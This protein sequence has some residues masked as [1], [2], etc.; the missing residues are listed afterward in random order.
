MKKV[1]KS[2]K[3]FIGVTLVAIALLFVQAF[4]DL[5]LPNYMSSIVNVGIQ[6]SGIEHASPESF[7]E[8]GY[9]FIASLLP[10]AQKN[11]FQDAYHLDSGVYKIDTSL[12]RKEVDL[13][14]SD[15]ITTLMLLDIEGQGGQGSIEVDVNIKDLYAATPLFE[16]MDKTEAYEKAQMKEETV[17]LQTGVMVA[18]LLYEDQGIST[19]SMQTNYIIKTGA[20]MLAITLLGALA[21]ISVSYVSA[22]IGAGFSRRLRN[23]I[24]SKVES[25]SSVEFNEFSSSSLVIRTTNDVTQVQQ[26]VVMGIRMFFYAPIMALGGIYYINQTETSLT[27]I[28]VVACSIIAVLFLFVALVA[29]PKFKIVQKYV[30]RLTL[31]F[32]EN[33]NGVMVIR[34]FG[35]KKFENERFDK[36]NTDSANLSRFINRIMSSMMPL[37][38][39][40]MNLT[41]I[42]ILW[43]GAEQVSA[44]TM[45]VGDMM[46]F[47]QYTMQIIM[48]FLMIA[49]MFIFVPRAIVSL[50]RITEILDRDNV[51]VDPEN[52]Q[53]FNPEEIGLVEFNN[54][55]FK[56]DGADEYILKDIN[57]TAKPSQTTAIIGSTGSGKST[58]VNLIPR[59]YDVSEG[60]IKVNGVDVREVKQ[61]D[62]RESIGFIPQKGILLS[63][64]VESNLKYGRPDADQDDLNTALSISQSNFILNTEEGLESFVAQGGTNFSGGQRQR[65]S[66]AR[67]LVK[68][69][70][71]LKAEIKKAESEIMSLSGHVDNL[72]DMMIIDEM[73]QDILGNS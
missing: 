37:L 35:N 4:S 36:S 53:N 73:V 21:A 16:M 13:L 43:F 27:W 29:V 39:F 6:Q 15:A 14:V 60:S 45:Q 2:F 48:S 50:N 61:F 17:R 41:T 28:I 49:M 55:S 65:L 22:K 20:S 40:V 23:E 56:Y 64:D 34:A 58:L 42:A 7:N 72:E 51:I 10:D 24:F 8:D 59:F 12:D 67:A 46:A 30:D 9:R 70:E 25:F 26:M 63:G 31:V 62:L 54:V 32:R 66:I 69:D 18:K 38:M 68:A 11:E 47:M 33:L 5:K 52:P 19:S 57:F 71:S 3:P 1:F 44:A